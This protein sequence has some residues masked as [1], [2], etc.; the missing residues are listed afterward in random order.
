M[1]LKFLATMLLAFCIPGMVLAGL[2]RPVPVDINLNADDSGD[3]QGD[4]VTARFSDND[5][6]FI[7]CGVRVWKMA[8]GSY[9]N[10]G[11]CQARDADEVE[12]FCSTEDPDLLD[13]MKATSSYSFITFS[14]DA[15]EECTHI[16]FSTQSFYLPEH[17]SKKKPKKN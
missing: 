1:K 14:W 13:V 16:G 6:E 7:G 9:M 5:V 17:T 2:E 10:W 11:F 4:M 8:D 3:A 15:D 12:V